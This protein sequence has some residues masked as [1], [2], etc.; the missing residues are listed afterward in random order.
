[1][2]PTLTWSFRVTGMGLVLL[3]ALSQVDESLGAWV[4]WT[5]IGCGSVGVPIVG[6]VRSR[7][8]RRAESAFE[9]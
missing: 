3:F 4:G 7:R 5:L 9:R 8:R 6:W 1:M 2:N